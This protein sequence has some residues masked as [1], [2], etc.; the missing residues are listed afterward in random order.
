MNVHCVVVDPAFV[1][2]LEIPEHAY[3]ERGVLPEP[4]PKERAA[5]IR[6]ARRWTTQLR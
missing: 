4:R 5:I 1:Q 2:Q 3:R 6:T